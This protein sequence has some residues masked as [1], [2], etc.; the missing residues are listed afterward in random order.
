MLEGFYRKEG[1]AIRYWVR[2]K[3]SDDEVNSICE[4]KSLLDALD[5]ATVFNLQNLTLHVS[6]KSYFNYVYRGDF[7]HN[8]GHRST[9][10][11]DKW[12]TTLN[13]RVLEN[14]N[15]QFERAPKT[16]SGGCDIILTVRVPEAHIRNKWK[17]DTKLLLGL[18]PFAAFEGKDAASENKKLCLK[19]WSDTHM[20]GK[21]MNASALTQ[22]DSPF[23]GCTKLYA[24]LLHGIGG[25]P[26]QKRE[27]DD[28]L[29]AMKH[30]SSPSKP[31]VLLA[32]SVTIG[33][34]GRVVKQ[35]MG[36]FKDGS[37]EERLSW[38]PLSELVTLDEFW[39]AMCDTGKAHEAIYSTGNLFGDDEW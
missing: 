39:D 29:E 8:D 27:L 18:D 14:Q 34:M 11:L 22:Y 12:T 4:L 10:H 3:H 5:L 9:Y 38:I 7:A 30:N 28:W 33:S 6:Q 24:G 32:P 15:D 13:E 20:I 19:S 1:D 26:L 37:G 36:I 35:W 16:V 23:K 31:F 25:K 21:S 2:D 17:S